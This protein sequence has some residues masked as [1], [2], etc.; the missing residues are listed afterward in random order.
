V[1]AAINGHCQASGLWLAC[2]ADISVASDRARFRLPELRL[3]VAAP[4][5]ALVLPALTG[6][7]RAKDLALTG[8]AFGADEAY[9]MG[10]VARIAPH[11]RLAAAATEVAAGLIEAAPDARRAWKQLAHGALRP[12]RAEAVAASISTAEAAEGFAAFLERRPPHWSPRAA[13]PEGGA[14]RA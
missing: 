13:D 6:L 4:W 14:V 11:D 7:A 3:G 12:V 8:R 1:V 9:Q 2:L 5:S 10:L